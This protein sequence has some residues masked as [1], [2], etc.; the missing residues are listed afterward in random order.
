MEAD[1]QRHEA[2]SGEIPE[3]ATTG[4]FGLESVSTLAWY[5]QTK[6]LFSSPGMEVFQ[7]LPPICLFSQAASSSLQLEVFQ[8]VDKPGTQTSL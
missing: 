7:F 2:G 5:L 8:G 6:A 1:A 3:L 4:L